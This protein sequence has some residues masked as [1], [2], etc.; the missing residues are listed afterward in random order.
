ME[1]Q[2]RIMI[3]DDERSNRKVL[4][5]LLS[6]EFDIVL[7]KN[8]AQVFRRLN[9][10]QAIDL[11]LLDI[12]LPDTDGYEILRKMKNTEEQKNI[13][14]IFI[15]VLDSIEDE[16]KAFKTG[17]VDF[18]TKPFHPSI[19]KARVQ[20]QI[21]L[22][23]QRRM[24]EEMAGIDGLTGIN[25]RRS[26]D[27]IYHKEWQKAIRYGEPLSLIMGDVDFFKNYNDLYGHAAGDVVLKEIA[28]VIKDVLKRPE[29][30]VA[31]YGGEEFVVILPRTEKKGAG[32]IAEE[33]RQ[34]IE[35]LAIPHEQSSCSKVVTISL[36]GVT[37]RKEDTDPEA[38]LNQ[39]DK[40]LYKAKSEGR[41]RVV[42]R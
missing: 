4:S 39:S 36:G 24:L 37:H 29:D 19:V 38:F 34:A 2:H 26:F 18:I 13:P 22:I 33:I 9:S 30:A 5:D 1:K 42:W 10:D 6:D 8:A 31:R 16:E 15:T 28:K 32:K 20:N 3:V 23:E 7:A 21:K 35:S 41:N 40:M 11:I 17:A 27:T 12:M 25:N 14:V